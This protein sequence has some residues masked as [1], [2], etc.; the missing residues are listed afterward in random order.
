MACRRTMVATTAVPEAQDRR[1]H[2]CIRRM[3]LRKHPLAGQEGDY[4]GAYDE[5]HKR[6]GAYDERHKRR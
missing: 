1:R 3:S 2:R 4:K 6:R 5:Q